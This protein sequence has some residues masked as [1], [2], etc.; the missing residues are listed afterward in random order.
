MSRLPAVLLALSLLTGI[1]W[2][3]APFEPPAYAATVDAYLSERIAAIL[4]DWFGDWNGDGFAT[5]APTFSYTL[6]LLGVGSIVLSA[7]I[8]FATGSWLRRHEYRTREDELKRQLFEAK[9]RVPQLETSVRNRE[10]AV[11]RLKMEVDEWQARVEGLNRA[12]QERDQNL[13]DRDR[14][15]SKLSSEVTVLRASAVGG[16]SE[17]DGGRVVFA[18]DAPADSESVAVLKERLE[19]LE[20]ELDG[21]QRRLA[22]AERERERQD[23]WLDVMNDQLAR[24]RQ[25]NER[26]AAGGSDL[27]AA[28][29]RI[30]ELQE[31][32]GR[33]RTEL[34]DR[35]R[36]LAASRF[37]CANARTTVAY[38]Q[39]ELS[40]RGAEPDARATTH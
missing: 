20:G 18:Q 33:L 27:D 31:E 4:F 26:L 5:D 23:R 34:A 15:I 13:R 3:M 24:A 36:R 10:L 6:T 29:R 37:E 17:V 7:A 1:G 40:R 21:H 14:A 16:E 32:V 19:A 11:T 2:L 22:S 38:L 12:I 9:G 35:D 39:A 28:Q 8:G 25:E 30:A